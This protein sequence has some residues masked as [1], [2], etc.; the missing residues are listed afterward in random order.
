M[1]APA[2]HNALQA[3]PAAR[4]C[5]TCDEEYTPRTRHATRFCSDRCRMAFNGAKARADKVKE[6]GVLL[7]RTLELIAREGNCTT[8]ADGTGC[9]HC[10][11]QAA[12][13]GLKP[14]LEPK[15]LLEKAKA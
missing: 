3:A 8:A 11:A 4:V 7:Y 9:H 1:N 2:D 13:A 10:M 5:D 6:R 12:I 15:A 14:P